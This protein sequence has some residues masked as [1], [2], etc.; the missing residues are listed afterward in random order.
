MP[1]AGFAHARNRVVLATVQQ[2]DPVYADF[3]QKVADAREMPVERVREIARGR[4]WTGQDAY[5]LGLVDE[6][7]DMETAIT[8]AAELA[9]LEGGDYSVRVYPE[10]KSTWELIMERRAFRSAS[11]QLR[12]LRALI[13]GV[14]PFAH[15][16][17]QPDA[18]ETPRVEP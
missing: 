1:M 18:L 10:P 12:E 15:L 2:L 7:G 8:R 17:D 16:L 6:L 13:A 11:L 14:R 5:D 9:G 3:T 4:V